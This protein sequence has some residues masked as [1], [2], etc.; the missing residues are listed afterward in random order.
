MADESSML[1]MRETTACIELRME[2]AIVVGIKIGFSSFPFNR[3]AK[4][5]GWSSYPIGSIGIG[6]IPLGSNSH[7]PHRFTLVL[8]AG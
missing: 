4:A 7:R 5:A 8:A 1:A 3:S 6:T 2:L